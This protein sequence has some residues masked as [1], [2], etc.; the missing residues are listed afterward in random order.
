MATEETFNREAHILAAMSPFAA[1]ALLI[2]AALSL[3]LHGPMAGRTA[4]LAAIATGAVHFV[5]VFR[6]WLRTFDLGHQGRAYAITIVVAIAL[7]LLTLP[8]HREWRNLGLA[9]MQYLA[10]YG[11]MFF[12]LCLTYRHEILDLVE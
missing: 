3:R 4:H 9:L 11:T 8:H 2:A 1:P 7:A 12:A 10:A 6:R 5:L